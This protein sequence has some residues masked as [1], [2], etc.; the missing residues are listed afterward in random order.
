MEAARL[1]FRRLE[2]VSPVMQKFR[3]QTAS[4]LLN[5][6]ALRSHGVFLVL[7]LCRVVSMNYSRLLLQDFIQVRDVLQTLFFRNCSSSPCTRE[8][9]Q[10]PDYLKTLP[11]SAPLSRLCSHFPS[12][13]L[14]RSVSLSPSCSTGV[15]D[16]SPPP[17][18][19]ILLSGFAMDAQLCA[20][21]GSFCIL[22]MLK[23]LSRS[24]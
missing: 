11:V 21:K 16:L 7:R 12:L 4:S 10:K 5:S 22:S 20:V 8:L 23:S 17:P 2:S 15:S 13:R 24:S 14:P 18:P 6:P 1:V 19:P 3:L 9:N